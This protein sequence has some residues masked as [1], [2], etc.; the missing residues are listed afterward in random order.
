MANDSSLISTSERNPHYDGWR[1]MAI[2]VVL[3][4][5]FINIL[6]LYAGKFGVAAFFVLS[7]ALMSSILFVKRIP[8]ATFYKRRISRI[9]PVF[10]IYVSSVYFYAYLTSSAEFNHYFYR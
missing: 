3:L 1:G 6:G 10:F 2:A 9:F 7:G 5:H 4:S 8:L